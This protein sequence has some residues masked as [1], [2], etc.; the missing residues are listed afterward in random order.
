MKKIY[1]QPEADMTFMELESMIASS[2][3]DSSQDSQE[4]TTSENV[5]T[6]FA[7]RMMLLDV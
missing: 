1:L 4:V 7:S 2:T 3:L 5:L 6:E